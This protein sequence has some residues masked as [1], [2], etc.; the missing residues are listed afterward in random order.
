MK[1]ENCGYEQE[2]DFRP[3]IVKLPGVIDDKPY[4]VKYNGIF[5]CP[6]CGAIKVSEELESK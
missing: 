2:E 3:Y 6:K 1:C 5:V 4:F